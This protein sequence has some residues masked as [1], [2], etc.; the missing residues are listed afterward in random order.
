[1]RFPRPFRHYA[2]FYDAAEVTS[3]E[4]S[5]EVDPRE[6]GLTRDDVDAMWRSVER[7]Y[8]SGLHPA[9][10]L[11]V[12]RNGQVVLDRAVG[13][14]HGN[15]PGEPE[16]TPLVRATPR[17]LFSL[18]SASKCVTSMLIHLLDERGLISIEDPVTKYI[19]EFGRHGKEGITIRHLL[20]HRAGIPA[21]PGVGV[22]L[23]M[24][25]N[26]QRVL[27]IICEA[28]PVFAPGTQ[29]AY[30]AITTGYL[31]GE[32][33]ARVT[34][35]DIRTFLRQEILDPLKIEHLSYGVRPEEIPAVARNAFTGAPPLPPGSWIMQR[36]L[37]V[38]I[39]K[40]IEISNEPAYLTAVVPSANVICTANEA[41]RF[42]Q[43]LLQGGELDGVRI[44]KPE[45]IA[46]AVAPQHGLSFDA[47]LGMPISYALG[48]M[49]GRRWL[50][51]FGH[52]TPNAFGHIGF[53]AVTV[54]A[55]PAR[56]VAAALLTSGKPFLT[57]GQILWFETARTVSRRCRKLR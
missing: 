2:R 20:S 54:W 45:T 29:I 25:V 42:F 16:G 34:G 44:F 23:D 21:I 47:Y 43:L 32:I 8:S 19:P 11:C 14:S 31:F 7:L 22:E 38:P 35:R 49:R 30:H 33:I 4:G 26:P 24:V 6:A 28:K 46:R 48:F 55:D 39:E 56:G 57:P 50:S 17:T 18:Y 41:S 9:I 12:R 36:S 1:M 13:H 10:A 51:L 15:L 27:Q 5:A 53:T 40:A 3:R 37:G 52:D